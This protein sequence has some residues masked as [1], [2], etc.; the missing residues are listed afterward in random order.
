MNNLNKLLFKIQ[1]L[2]F[3]FKSVTFAII[4]G[5]IDIKILI[6]LAPATKV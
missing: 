2:I 1:M 5:T 4:G 6:S 3:E